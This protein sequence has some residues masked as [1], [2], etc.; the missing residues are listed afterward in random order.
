MYKI[1]PT[2][3]TVSIILLACN[4][5]L[6]G[7]K[8]IWYYSASEFNSLYTSF[9]GKNIVHMIVRVNLIHSKLVFLKKNITKNKHIE[10]KQCKWIALFLHC[11][12]RHGLKKTSLVTTQT[13]VKQLGATFNGTQTRPQNLV[14]PINSK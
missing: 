3:T 11:S 13:Q 6:S 2:R 12:L 5:I 7:I 10:K 8:L 9:S 14:G 4:K 1:H